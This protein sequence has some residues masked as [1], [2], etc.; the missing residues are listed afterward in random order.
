MKLV[1]LSD[2]HLGYRQYHRVTTG[3]LNQREADVALAFK[4]TMDAVIDLKPDVI[5]IGGDVFHSVRPTTPAILH[6]YKQFARLR[7]T[8]PETIVVM[9]AG[10]HDTPR[11][12]ETGHIIRLFATLG[13]TVVDTAPKRIVFRDGELSILAVPS[14]IRPRPAFDPDPSSTSPQTFELVYS[15]EPE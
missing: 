9:V 1:H 10:N 5:V 6:A 4:K 14:L 11:T 13:I 3:G 12:T 8:L 7:E 2:L 15:S